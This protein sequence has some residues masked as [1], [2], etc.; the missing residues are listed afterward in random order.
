MMI[1]AD[2]VDGAGAA[3]PITRMLEN[4]DVQYIH[5]HYAKRG[6]FAATI[7]RA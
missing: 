4:P 2:L 5:A 3:G 7:T 1:D 6:C